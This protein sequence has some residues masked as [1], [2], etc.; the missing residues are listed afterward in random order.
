MSI[1]ASMVDVDDQASNYS[2]EIM[3]TDIENQHK[4]VAKQRKKANKKFKTLDN[5]QDFGEQLGA[6]EEDGIR[7]AEEQRDSQL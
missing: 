7:N 3:N 1:N 5:S 4:I 6:N 2:G